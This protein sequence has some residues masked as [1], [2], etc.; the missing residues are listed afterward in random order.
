MAVSAAVSALSLRSR[1]APEHVGRHRHAVV[2]V[3]VV[4]VGVFVVFLPTFV[5]PL[6]RPSFILLDSSG[7][8]VSSGSQ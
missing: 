6:F 3:L 1:R 7:F 4:V 5:F 8:L 2:V